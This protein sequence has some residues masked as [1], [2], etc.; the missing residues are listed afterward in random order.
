MLYYKR[1]LF[2]IMAL[3]KAF[4]R[5][6]AKFNSRGNEITPSCITHTKPTTKT[7][8]C[9][10]PNPKLYER[11]KIIVHCSLR[12]DHEGYHYDDKHGVQ[13]DDHTIAYNPE[14][15]KHSIDKGLAK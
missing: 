14:F 7:E 12:R 3:S 2:S 8:Q 10:Q 15:L 13:W 5:A 6:L 9:L 4:K 11:Y 1:K